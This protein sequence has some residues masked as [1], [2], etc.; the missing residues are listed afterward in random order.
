MKIQ[1]INGP[2]LNLL[3]TR[4]PQKYGSVTFEEYLPVLKE[5]YGEISIEY[6]QSNIEGM[7]IDKLQEIGFSYD[8]I[9]INAGGYTHTSISIAD[10]LRSVNAPAVEVHISNI[11]A[12]EEYRHISF[13][14]NACQGSI[15][16]FGLD[17]YRLA[18]EALR[19]IHSNKSEV[20][21]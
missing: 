12:R 3:G 5:H 19:V 8:G 1:I 14:A 20:K 21:K 2:N 18:I 16:G 4:E 10:A 7:I 11:L 15:M 17:S 9:V 6:F 13:I